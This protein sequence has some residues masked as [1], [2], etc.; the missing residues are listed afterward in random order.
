RHLSSLSGGRGLV[1]VGD[2][3]YVREEE[4]EIAGER[5]PHIAYHGSLSCMV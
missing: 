4:M 2:K 3:G 5:D 1:L